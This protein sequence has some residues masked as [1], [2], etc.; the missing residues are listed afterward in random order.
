MEEF[1]GQAPD[2]EDFGGETSGVDMDECA[3][4]LDG[5]RRQALNDVE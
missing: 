4:M 1:S 3:A 2:R 5:L